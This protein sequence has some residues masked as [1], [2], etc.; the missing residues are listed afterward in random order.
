MVNKIQNP[1][2]VSSFSLF[3]HGWRVGDTD[4]FDLAAFENK[5]NG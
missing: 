2:L 3:D 5:K 1:N 4:L